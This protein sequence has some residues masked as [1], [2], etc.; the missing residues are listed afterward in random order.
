MK[1]LQN[2]ALYKQNHFKSPSAHKNNKSI[3]KKVDNL[4]NKNSGKNG[5]KII[6]KTIKKELNIDK[7]D[8]LYYINNNQ[9]KPN[10]QYI[11]IKNENFYIDIIK[12]KKSIKTRKI[13]TPENP[14]KI[15]NKKKKK[16][17]FPLYAKKFPKN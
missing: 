15:T 11:D 13:N 3:E 1:M 12:V 10:D 17:P 4:Y 6:N 9:I 5:L 16:R 14:T 2:V 7:F 8:Y